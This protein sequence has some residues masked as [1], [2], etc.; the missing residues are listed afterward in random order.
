MQ[1]LVTVTNTSSQAVNN[2]AL[3]FDYPATISDIWNAKKTT[4]T[5]RKYRVTPESWATT[6][7]AGQ[8]ATFGFIANPGS[9]SATLQNLLIEFDG[10]TQP[11]PTPTATPIP[12]ATPSPSATPVPS[13]TPTPTPS[14]TPG[15]TP[16]PT[17]ATTP[18]PTPTPT[19]APSPNP[20]PTPDPVG[21]PTAGNILVGYFAEWG[22]YQRNYRVT[23]I[24]AKKLNVINYAFAN[25]S[26]AGEVMLYDSYAA[27][28]YAYPG[29]TWDQPMR[30]NFNQLKKLK[31][32]NPHLRT[33]ISV[34]G[35]TLSG[36]FSDVALT[37]T[38]RQKFAKSAVKFIRD[39][40]FDGV[41][42]DW[43]YPVSGGLPANKYRAADKVNYTLLLQEV[44]RQLDL[45]STADGKKYYLTIAVGAGADK[46]ANLEV[47]KIAAILDWINIM[48]YDFHGST[49]E[50]KT[51]HHAG[52][53]SEVDTLSADDA[54]R[55]YL[56]AG[57]P[58]SKLVLGLG[59]YGRGWKGI[60]ATNNGLYQTSTSPSWDGTATSQ[61]TFENGVLD[62][63]D[64]ADRLRREPSVYQR[65]W[66][67]VAKVPW[68]Y[69]PTLEGGTFYTYD[70]PESIRLKVRYLK[71]KGL[72]GAMFWE[73]DSDERAGGQ[74]G[75]LDAINDEMKK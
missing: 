35:W 17:P 55:G 40:G 22:I 36:K 62:Y 75:L 38:S 58:A 71:Q 1:V 3:Q 19:P 64:I 20:T 10:V 73:L 29:D 39:Y 57:A 18:T 5:N 21:G 14:P 9:N 67:D 13:A 44:R 8:S 49:W 11:T 60:P 51:G 72:G 46:I 4:G 24:P 26:D 45:A 37:S 47:A 33:L 31:A 12:S 42:I 52:L 32:A 23:D 16:T 68:V 50:T 7:A 27:I 74:P 15:S 61:G 63:W 54:V 48:A 56:N 59:F 2:W 30:G 43:E 53:Y 70:D 65:H 6:L 34:G 66:D 25:I 41:D 28:D 69:A